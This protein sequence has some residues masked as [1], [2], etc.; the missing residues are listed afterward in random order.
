M[1]PCTQRSRQQADGEQPDGHRHQYMPTHVASSTPYF[2][3]TLASCKR[4]RYRATPLG[5][6]HCRAGQRTCPAP[7]PRVWPPTSAKVWEKAAA[8]QVERPASRD[9][10]HQSG[11]G[12]GRCVRSWRPPMRKVLGDRPAGSGNGNVGLWQQRVI[13]HARGP[14]RVARK[15]GN[16]MRTRKRAA[17]FG[18]GP[19]RRSAHRPM[20]GLL[21]SNWAVR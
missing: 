17:T 7:H 18:I 10:F 12:R 3:L 16:A 15:S 2:H 1:T 19:N 8:E 9:R 6:L 14:N 11:R 4:A 5:P 21:G 20:V 13:L